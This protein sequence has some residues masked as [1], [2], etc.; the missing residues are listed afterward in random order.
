MFLMFAPEGNP[1]RWFGQTFG[2]HLI[3]Y[4]FLIAA[5]VALMFLPPALWR[6]LRRVKVPG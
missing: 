2:C 5:V 6:R 3:G 1:L 4:P